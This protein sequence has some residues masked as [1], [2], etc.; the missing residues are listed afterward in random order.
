MEVKFY[1]TEETLNRVSTIIENKEKGAYFRFGDGDVNLALGV[2]EL[3]QQ[4][5][6]KLKYLM[7]DA[8]K[9]NH[10][11]VLRTLPLHCKELETLED[12]MF[13]GNHEAPL[14]WCEDIVNNFRKITGEKGQIELYSNVALSHTALQTPDK[15]L[16]FLKQISNQV[17]YFIGNEDIPR[18]ILETLFGKSVIH[19][20]TPSRS[21][22]SK[23][24]EIYQE[25]KESI[26]NHSD[27]SVVVTSMG[28]SGRAMQKRIWDNHNNLFLFDFGSLMD[29]LCGW[30]TRAWIEMTN[31]DREKFISKFI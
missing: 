31:F 14:N 15:A 11:N 13:S 7:I 8:M 24:E 16:L 22:F 23:F 28:C 12:G 9:L 26:S 25:F 21:S 5:D 4:S 30:Q 18:E 2:S 3:L 6:E 1:S 17:K 19:I 29:A 20:K 10:P 27:Y